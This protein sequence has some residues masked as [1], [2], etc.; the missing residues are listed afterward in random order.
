M[1]AAKFF[2]KRDPQ[3]TVMFELLEPRGIENV[4]QVTGDHDFSGGLLRTEKNITA[5][6]PVEPGASS[7]LRYACSR[8]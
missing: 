2:D 5:D 1:G 4:A 3:P 6:Q 8:R 7:S